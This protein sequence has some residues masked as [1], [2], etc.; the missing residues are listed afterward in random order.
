V[1]VTDSVQSANDSCVRKV[2]PIPAVLTLKAVGRNPDDEFQLQVEG[3]S[4]EGYLAQVS[5]DLVHWIEITPV[6]SVDGRWILTDRDAPN[7]SQRFYR[8]VHE[9]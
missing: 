4:L 8:L 5:D 3:V 2:N 7:H 1:T 6:E 9:P